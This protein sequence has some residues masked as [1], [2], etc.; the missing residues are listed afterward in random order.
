MGRINQ[1]PKKLH[2]VRHLPDGLRPEPFKFMGENTQPAQRQ[3]TT[4]IS[5]LEARR[6]SAPWVTRTPNPQLR[7]LQAVVAKAMQEA[8]VAFQPGETAECIIDAPGK[9]NP[10]K[11]KPFMLYR[12]EDDYGV[13][14]YTELTLKSM[15]VL[16]DP[17]GYTC[18][19]I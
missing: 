8:G 10:E 17:L 13:E 14:K 12:S 6:K 2:I 1:S 4:S 19:M 11:A 9:K 18:E 3:I 7:R 15:A 16:L 5:H